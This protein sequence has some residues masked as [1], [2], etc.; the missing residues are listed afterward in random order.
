MEYVIIE[1][2]PD[3]AIDEKTLA[4]NFK[5]CREK[6]AKPV[7]VVLPV[8]ATVKKNYN[9]ND[10]KLFR[11]MI[12]KV[13][14]KYKAEFIDLFDDKPAD[15]AATSALLSARLYFANVVSLENIL[16][17]PAEFFK[18]LSKYFPKD[19]KKLIQHV[20][21]KLACDDFNRLSKTLPREILLDLMANV[22]ANM[23]YNHLANL[24]DMLSKDDYNDLAARVFKISAEKIRRKNK[25]KV[26]FYFAYSSFYFGDDLYNL[27]AN[28]ERFE[29]T[30]FINTKSGNAAINSERFQDA[31]RFKKMA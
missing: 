30:L 19:C 14:K 20:F 16:N 11:D 28:D 25:I 8:S 17:M 3:Q 22:F 2:S 23:T 15:A 4:D 18:I 5:L 27:F 21:C 29:P 31:E 10:L 9:A 1:L 12:N 24:S 13:V 26:G 7:C 6:G